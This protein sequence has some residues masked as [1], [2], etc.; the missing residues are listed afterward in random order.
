MFFTYLR[1]LKYIYIYIFFFSSMLGNCLKIRLLVLRNP[2]AHNKP[3]R[4][5]CSRIKTLI[6]PISKLL[7]SLYV[8][9]K[10][11]CRS[12]I[13][14]HVSCSLIVSCT[15]PQS[16]V[17]LLKGAIRV[18]SQ[19]LSCPG[20]CSIELLHLFLAQGVNSVQRIES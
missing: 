8:L 3:K 19:K 11:Q 6:I 15:G 5:F 13:R 7:L 17:Y 18:T 14:L 10:W 4:Q 2:K 12:L 20:P 1:Y 9:E 16:Q